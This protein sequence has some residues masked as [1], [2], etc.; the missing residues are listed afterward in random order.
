M[1][2]V[3][4]WAGVA[5]TACS[6]SSPRAAVGVPAAPLAHGEHLLETPDG[7]QIYYRV[8]GSGND[9]IVAIHGGPGFDFEV[10]APDLA[11]LETRQTVVYY[12]QRGGG[13]SSI[14]A[15]ADALTLDRHISDLEA[16]RAHLGLERMTLLGHSWGGGL[17]ARY[18]LRYPERMTRLVLVDP[19]P[20]RMTPYIERFLENVVRWMNDAELAELERLEAEAENA[21]DL[22]TAC[23][24]LYALLIR[25]YVSDPRMPPMFRADF[26]S[27]SQ[28]ALANRD[29]VYARTLESLG[30]WDWRRDL[31]SLRA[32]TLVIHGVDDPIPL[33]AAREWVL[34]LPNATFELIERSGHFP[35]VEQPDA[36]YAAV[37][38]F[39]NAE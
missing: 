3:L 30:D 32:P 17:A 4:V 16:L 26:C 19:M 25:G 36:F 7:I 39:L 9:V 23:R 31:G 21:S 27:G 35:Y 13:R 12:D 2:G 20:P 1:L 34:A 28:A 22:A 18:A 33:D 5:L 38:K 15:E 37:G 6:V 8:A 14:V 11:P 10:L 29:T 24:N